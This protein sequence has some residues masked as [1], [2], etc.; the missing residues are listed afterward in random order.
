MNMSNQADEEVKKLRKSE[1]T[2]VWDQHIKRLKDKMSHWERSQNSNNMIPDSIEDIIL[3]D[4][5]LLE[6]F[7]EIDDKVLIYGGIVPTE[8]MK[9]FLSSNFSVKLTRSKKKLNQR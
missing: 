7:G 3:S 6:M 2:R 1:L 9:H 4:E 5:K 8:N